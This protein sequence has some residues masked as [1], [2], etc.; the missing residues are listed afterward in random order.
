M[1]LIGFW[2]SFEYATESV[3]LGTESKENILGVRRSPDQVQLK[4]KDEPEPTFWLVAVPGDGNG[5]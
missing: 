3:T 5:K 2:G 4:T 1:Q